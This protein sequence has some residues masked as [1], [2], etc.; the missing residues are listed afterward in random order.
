MQ[1]HILSGTEPKFQTILL[2]DLIVSGRLDPL[3]IEVC[4]IDAFEVHDVGSH[5]PSATMHPIMQHSMLLT[6]RTMI[7]GYVHHSPVFA[8]Q[9]PRKSVDVHD[10][11]LLRAVSSMLCCIIG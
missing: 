9:V 1:Q 10:L 2:L 8:E 6:A 5:L 11:A 7:G 3:T 4:A